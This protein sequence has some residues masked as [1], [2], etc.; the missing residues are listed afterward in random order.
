M[1]AIL[2]VL[3]RLWRSTLIVALILFAVMTLCA[4]LLLR[5][6]TDST[7]RIL[8]ASA[9]AVHDVFSVTPE[10]RVNSI[11]IQ[12]QT[13][14]IA[15]LAVVEREEHVSVKLSE[16]EELLHIP[17]LLTEKSLTVSASFRVKAGFDLRQPFSISQ[18]TGGRVNA[19]FPEAKVLSVEMISGLDSDTQGGWLNGVTEEDRKKMIDLLNQAARDAAEQS[20][21]VKD[22]HDQVS[23][24]LNEVLNQQGVPRDGV[25]MTWRP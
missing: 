21:I 13:R 4:L 20:S 16:H 15:E 24:R 11:V 19:S 14:P 9:K 8:N 5:Q 18:E 6:C 10:V 23:E 22:A 2:Q 7:E 1:A 12:T 25:N 17:I 3:G